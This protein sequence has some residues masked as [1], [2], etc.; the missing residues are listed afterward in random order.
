MNQG[1]QWPLDLS[2]LNDHHKDTFAHIKGW[3]ARRDRAFYAIAALLGFLFLGVYYPVTVKAVFAKS[4]TVAGAE[5]DL[6]RLPVEVLVSLG[7]AVLFALVLRHC[8]ASITVDRQYDYLHLVEKK[9]S[10]ASGDPDLFQREG[11][12]Y[13][14]AYPAFSWWAYAFYAGIFPVT[15]VL[16]T[17]RLLAIECTSRE[18]FSPLFDGF[19]WLGVVVSFF[20]YRLW[21]II[22]KVCCKRSG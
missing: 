12:A 10:T 20:L 22:A 3:E 19:M 16:V 5:V 17:G 8:Q 7:W 15:T 11:R 13:L 21:P 9:I 6:A 18:R 4:A 1:E 14:L 2:I